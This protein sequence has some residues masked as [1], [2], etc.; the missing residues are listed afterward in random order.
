VVYLTYQGYGPFEYGN[1]TKNLIYV[2][3]L[4][5][6]YA[7]AVLFLAPFQ[8]ARRIRRRYLAVLFSAW[9]SFFLVIYFVTKSE[10]HKTLNDFNRTIAV[11]LQSIQENGRRYELLLEGTSSIFNVMPNLN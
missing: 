1:V 6:G 2:Q 5:A 9:A 7:A 3:T 11:A 8:E 10:K 4:I